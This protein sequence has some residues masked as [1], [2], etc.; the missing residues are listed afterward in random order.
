MLLR[1]MLTDGTNEGLI[2]VVSSGYRSEEYQSE[3]LD[4]SIQVNMTMKEMNY[5]DAYND[6]V[7]TLA[8]PGKSEHSTGL[9]LDIVSLDYQNLDDNQQYTEE[10]KWLRKNCYKYGFILRYPKGKSDITGYK[11][12]PWHYRYVGAN[13][14][15][16]LREGNA[17]LEEY[18]NIC[19]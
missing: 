15:Y 1:D 14:S 6:A 9:A 7:M 16:K 17:T 8:P 11:F 2:F 10:N 4:E 13:I 3:L 19:K 12:E 18:L 5:S